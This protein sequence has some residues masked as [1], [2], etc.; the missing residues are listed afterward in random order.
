[1]TLRMVDVPTLP[2]LSFSVT[3]ISRNVSMPTRSPYSMTTS[4]PMSC[5]AIVLIASC[6]G[7]SG[8][9]VKSTLPLT[10]RMSLTCM[11]VSLQSA[12]SWIDPSGK[13]VKRKARAGPPGLSDKVFALGIWVGS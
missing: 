3:M 11:P 2:P 10:L 6:S 1:M 5:D 12:E 4:E 13:A 8:V 7:V 9:T